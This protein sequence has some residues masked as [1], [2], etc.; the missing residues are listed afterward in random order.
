MEI[1]FLVGWLLEAKETVPSV[2]G[3][4]VVVRVEVPLTVVGA[5]PSMVALSKGNAAS[6]VV[7]RELLK[8]R[9]MGSGFA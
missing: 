4:A 5:I 9:L 8:S 2:R 7:V 1:P 3:L 6:V